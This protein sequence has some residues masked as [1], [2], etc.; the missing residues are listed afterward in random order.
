MEG[1]EVDANDPAVCEGIQFILEGFMAK[2][3]LLDNDAPVPG[4]SKS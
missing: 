4:E 3:N 2:G 1:T